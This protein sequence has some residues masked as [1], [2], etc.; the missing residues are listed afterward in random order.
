MVLAILNMLYHL[1]MAYSS[2]S[3]DDTEDDSNRNETVKLVYDSLKLP[4]TE[5]IKLK[6]KIDAQQTPNNK[7][8]QQQ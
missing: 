3:E 8:Q 5:K 4:R 6:N 1:F 7:Q 2:N